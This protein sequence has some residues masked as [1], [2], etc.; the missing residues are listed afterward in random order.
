MQPVTVT[1]T[2]VSPA[3]VLLGRLV[4]SAFT[5]YMLL[6]LLRWL[7]PFLELDPYA[8]RM[9][10]LSRLADPVIR[11][12]R[13]FVPPSSSGDWAPIVA[14]LAVWVCRELAVKMVLP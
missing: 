14:L 11:A 13:Q 2:T 5:L 9:R 1:F 7:A 3:A 12:V 10:W 4:F 6:I 8:P